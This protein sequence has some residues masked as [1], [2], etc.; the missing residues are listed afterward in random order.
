MKLR[1]DKAQIEEVLIRMNRVSGIAGSLLV[2][3]EGEI[4]TGIYGSDE[5]V[6]VMENGK[7]LIHKS[8]KLIERAKHGKLK[9]ILIET[10][11]GNLIFNTI[12]DDNYLFIE[13][14]SGAY[15]LKVMNA[16]EEAIISLKKFTFK[17]ESSANSTLTKTVLPDQPDKVKIEQQYVFDGIKTIQKKIEEIPE[18]MDEIQSPK[19]G[20][21]NK[22]E[23]YFFNGIKTIPVNL[24]N[25]DQSIAPEKQKPTTPTLKKRDFT[26]AGPVTEIKVRKKEKSLKIQSQSNA[27]R[28]APTEKPISPHIKRKETN[29]SVPD[30]PTSKLEAMVQEKLNN[31]NIPKKSEKKDDDYLKTDLTNQNLEN[32]K[33][34]N[35]EE[36]PTPTFEENYFNIPGEPDPQTEVLILEK[37]KDLTNIVK[38]ATVDAT[39]LEET[40]SPKKKGIEITPPPVK[41]AEKDKNVPNDDEKPI[42]ISPP[43]IKTQ[44]TGNPIHQVKSQNVG[45]N[46]PPPLDRKKTGNTSPPLENKKKPVQ[47]KDHLA[48]FKQ[49]EKDGKKEKKTRRRTQPRRARSGL[50]PTFDMARSMTSERTQQMEENQKEKPVEKLFSL[51]K[52]KANEEIPQRKQH[53]VSVQEKT[54]IQ[55]ISSNIMAKSITNDGLNNIVA[56]SSG[57]SKT[58]ILDLF[59]SSPK[60][61]KPNKPK[62]PKKQVKP[63]HKKKKAPSKLKEAESEDSEKSLAFAR[64]KKIKLDNVEPVISQEEAPKY[65]GLRALIG[66]ILFSAYFGLSF[67]VIYYL[68]GQSV[69]WWYLLTIVPWVCVIF[70]GGDRLIRYFMELKKQ[71]NR[72]KYVKNMKNSQMLQK[73]EE[74]PTITRN[75]TYSPPRYS[76]SLETF[77]LKPYVILAAVYNIEDEWDKLWPH[78]KHFKDHLFF[79]DDIS[80]DNTMEV[81]SHAGV[82]I[83]PNPIKTNK[84]GG[85]LYGISKL[86]PD[87]ETVVVID[88]DIELPDRVTLERAIFDQQ[89]SGAGAV[90][91][92]VLPSMNQEHNVLWR[93]Q[94]VEYSD[95]MSFGKTAQHDSIFLSGAAAIFDKEVLKQHL[96]MSS[97][98]VYAE[99]LEISM[100]ILIS[101]LR[102]YFDKRVIFSTDVPLTLQRITLQRIGWHFGMLRVAIPY[103]LKARSKKDT[104]FYYN[105]YF[106]I[107]IINILIHPLKVLAIFSYVISLF[108]FLLGFIFP[109]LLQY[110]FMSLSSIILISLFYI[111]LSAD[112]LIWS[113][114]FS[115]RDIGTILYFAL[116][117]GYLNLLPITIGY[118]NY[119]LYFF[120]EKKLVNDPYEKTDTILGR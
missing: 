66:I 62:K 84:P 89:R 80:K 4:L 16:I 25:P 67:V 35:P 39:I 118:L 119:F 96:L 111:I 1:E 3:S 46:S 18:I 102:T 113:P 20:K 74:F 103:I 40:P 58:G 13:T 90:G 104:L 64:M 44:K 17:F 26:P 120:F 34:T 86:D 112:S 95:S 8:H 108:A 75:L 79:V 65:D 41:D 81:V 10:Q 36:E 27:A 29:K 73:Y 116:Y 101:D 31:I 110:Q 6:P 92:Q 105:F 59:K 15:M 114:D 43:P 28:V 107:L 72:I 37:I 115:Y 82:K 63:I 83:I 14:R 78:L 68:Y 76:D 55:K 117:K 85:L 33:N 69:S 98:S 5:E 24:E 23:Q 49:I 45:N 9:Q 99:D 53:S 42:K 93:C 77:D 38:K 11:K 94:Y 100:L 91:V 19:P 22:D 106:Y 51:F 97:R 60:P 32:K 88:P 52:G 30:I 50:Q 70:D 71:F 12:N 48:K 87:I 109:E 7:K 21:P 61:D 57:K 56:P 2:N 54:P 47:V